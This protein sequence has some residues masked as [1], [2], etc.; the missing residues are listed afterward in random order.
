[1][2]LELSVPSVLHVCCM[3][4]HSIVDSRQANSWKKRQTYKWQSVARVS[5]NKK[6]SHTIKSNQIISNWYHHDNCSSLPTSPPSTEQI[7]PLEEMALAAHFGAKA[8][9]G[10]GGGC[11]EGIMA[12]SE[13][14]AK[15]SP[16]KGRPTNPKDALLHW[17]YM[18]TRSYVSISARK[19]KTTC[20]I[21][22]SIAQHRP[23]LTWRKYLHSI[24]CT[25]LSPGQC[26]RWK[27]FFVL[28][29]WV[30][31]LRP[32]APLF[33]QR[34]RLREIDERIA[35]RKLWNSL[36]GCRVSWTIQHN[37]AHTIMHLK[38]M[39]SSM[40]L[41]L[42]LFHFLSNLFCFYQ[43]HSNQ[44]SQSC[45]PAWCCREKAKVYPLL[46]VDDMI[47]MGDKPDWKCVYTYAQALYRGLKPFDATQKWESAQHSTPSA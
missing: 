40:K 43:T 7:E 9:G 37:Y 18:K 26:L 36:Q 39:S 10:G 5:T 45:A 30:G 35:S 25:P 6:H 46:E 21:A 2:K 44:R 20:S 22:H 47:K 1:M 11:G 28:G 13:R 12:A 16:V 42:F 14:P 27:L 17:C 19:A 33:P 38:T 3:M 29:R 32:I 4:S 15:T 31:F 8:A 34:Y 23:L 41:F 24:H